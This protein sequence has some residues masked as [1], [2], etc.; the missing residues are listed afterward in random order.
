MPDGDM[1]RAVLAGLERAGL[2]ER[3]SKDGLGRWR[4]NPVNGVATLLKS[5]LLLHEG[6]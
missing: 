6:M 1:L 2:M 4:V 3:S 5:D